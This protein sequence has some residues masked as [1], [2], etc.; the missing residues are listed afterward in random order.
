M[1]ETNFTF[2]V[3]LVY[4]VSTT[5]TSAWGTS[6]AVQST[7]TP[8]ALSHAAF[9]SVVVNLDLENPTK[10]SLT[11]NFNAT[12]EFSLVQANLLGK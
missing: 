10:I 1:L 4:T 11:I 9:E 12:G 5:L 6:P 7:D 8:I 2:R 3:F